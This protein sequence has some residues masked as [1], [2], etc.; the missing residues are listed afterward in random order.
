MRGNYPQIISWGGNVGLTLLWRI[1]RDEY[2]VKYDNYIY[3][4]QY[5]HAYQKKN[6]KFYGEVMNMTFFS[7]VNTITSKM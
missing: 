7:N 6:G 3:N 5:D 4:N 2:K 1:K